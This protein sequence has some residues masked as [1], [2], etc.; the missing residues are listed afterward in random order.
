[1]AFPYVPN[2]GGNW[3]TGVVGATPITEAALD[4]LETQF[5]SI[6]DLLTT[7]GDISY[8]GA[9][10]WE[11]LAKGTEGQFLRQGANDPAWA[12]IVDN[13]AIFKAGDESVNDS[14]VLQNDDD[15]VLAVGANDVWLIHML[16]YLISATANPDLDYAFAVP[17]GGAVR[18]MDAW[19]DT[20]ANPHSDG[21]NERTVALVNAEQ[22]IQ[23]ICLYIGGGTAGN[24]Q[25]QWAQHAAVAED[26]TV[27]ANSFMLCHQ[28]V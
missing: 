6:I 10:T 22:Y 13:Q 25:L 26:T 28:L 9:A 20:T 2:Y 19:S 7:R 1:M 18:I 11:R 23:I 24:L 12:S 16:L 8:R 21:T 17:A 5:Q 4:N 15:L 14:I 3:Q 27:K